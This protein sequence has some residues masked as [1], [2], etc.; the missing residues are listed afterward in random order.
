MARFSADPAASADPENLP[1]RTLFNVVEE[2]IDVDVEETL[3]SFSDLVEDDGVD[4]VRT[5]ATS[6][7]PE[8]SQPDDTASSPG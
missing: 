2:T 3:E 7:Q 5:T 1:L 4:D 8:A 6:A